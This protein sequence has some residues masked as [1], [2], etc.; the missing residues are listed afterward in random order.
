MPVIPALGELRQEIISS[1]PASG[2]REFKDSLGNLTI[3]CVKIKL[4]KG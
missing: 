3:P 2:N 4:E 1:R